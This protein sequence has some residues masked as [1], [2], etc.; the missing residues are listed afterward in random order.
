MWYK[1]AKTI[2]KAG[3]PPVPVNDTIVEILKTLINEEQKNFLL[4]FRK[5]S[6]NINQ[7]RAKSDL[8]EEALNTMLDDLMRVGLLTGIPSRSTDIMVYRLVAFLPGMLET[9]LMRGET[10]EKQKKLAKLWEQ[11]F[12]DMTEVTQKH[13]DIVMNAFKKAPAIDRVL[14]VE[15]EIEVQEEIVLPFEDVNKI[16]DNYDTIGLFHCYCRHQKDLL[17]DPCKINAP[18]LNCMSFGRSAKFLIDYD[19]AKQISKEE[20]LKIL[21]E[22]ED[23]GLVHKVFHAR[24]NPEMEEIGLCSCCKCCCGGFQSYY[25]GTSPIHMITSYIAKVNEEI[26]IGCGTCV[27][28]CPIE[29]INLVDS[30]AAVIV[31]K[32]IGCGVCAHHCPEN[33]MILKR[34]G[35]RDVF[36]PALKIVNT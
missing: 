31:D 18:R 6:L 24:G 3:G 16:V 29:A 25:R 34:T 5:A 13:Y 36:I 33:A 23:L 17:D 15:E 10:G 35:L 8:D 27:D 14:P 2:I 21:R 20:A 32:C 12:K 11:L 19:F 22:A 1:L 7:I 30:V 9:T 4:I 28:M 26:C